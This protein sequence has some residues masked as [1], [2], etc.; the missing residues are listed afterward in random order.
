VNKGAFMGVWSRVV[1]PR[2]M[3]RVRSRK[4]SRMMVSIRSMVSQGGE[5]RRTMMM[6]RVEKITV[7]VVIVRS[8][9]R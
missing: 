5:V 9:I 3:S 2:E 6:S 8:T 7:I 4:R 1:K